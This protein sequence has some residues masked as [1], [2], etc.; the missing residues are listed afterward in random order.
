MFNSIIVGSIQIDCE[1][2]NT[3]KNIKNARKYI[4]E[5]VKKNISI[6]VLPELF[7]IGYDLERFTEINYD[8]DKTIQDISLLAKENNI[9]IVAGLLEKEGAEYYNSLFVFTNEGIIE[10]I[11]RKNYLFSLSKENKIF[12]AGNEIKFFNINNIR[13]GLLICYDIRFPELSRQYIDEE[14]DVLI[15][16][17]AFPQPRLEHWNVLLKARAIEN[18]MYVIAS[19]RVGTDGSLTFLGNSQIIDPWGEEIS[20][21]NGIREGLIVGEI[22]KTYIEEVRNKIPCLKERKK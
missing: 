12:K 16:S 19:N 21:I 17:A 22:S 5:A 7:V 13:F 11:Y 9:Y 8:Q 20:R 3:N 2:G 10:T 18:Q 15:C 14:C 6:V 4:K 1:V